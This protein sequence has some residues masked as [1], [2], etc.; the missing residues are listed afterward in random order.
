MEQVTAVLMDDYDSKVS[1]T[2]EKLVELRR[3]TSDEHERLIEELLEIYATT[4]GKPV[5]VASMMAAVT[6]LCRLVESL[7]ASSGEMKENV[8]VACVCRL[9]ENAMPNDTAGQD[10]LERVA[11]DATASMIHFLI[12][13][14]NGKLGISP[15]AKGVFGC[16]PCCGKLKKRRG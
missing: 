13:A 3:P 1:E 10:A 4:S 5:T 16:L 12:S 8:V 6:D 14:D 15:A 7:D 9:V 11:V 2:R